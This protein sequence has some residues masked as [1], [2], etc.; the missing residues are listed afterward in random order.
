MAQAIL[1]DVL[2]HL[3]RL[4]E[5]RGARDLTD[6]EL[7]DRFRTR[8]EEAA[9]AV[10]VE[11]H[12]RMVLGVCRRVLGDAHA[13]EDA[14][15]AT[16]L[17]L[18]RRTASVRKRDSVVAWL[19]G[20][21][22]RIALRAKAQAAARR[23]RERQANP[24]PRADRL[25]E[26]TWQELRSALDE[27]V[28]AL[29]EKYR[30]PVVLCYLEGKSYEQA[31][32]ELGCPKSSLASRLA[33]ARAL[34]R[35]QLGR[36]GFGLPAGALAGTFAEAADAAP[37][38]ALLTLN[39]VKAA[40][41]IAAGKA[42]PGGCLSARALA[43][44][45]EA[46]K[47]IPG[48]K[49]KLALALLALALAVGGA[50]AG[51]LLTAS[52]APAAEVAVL[53]GPAP[54]GAEEPAQPAAGKGRLQGRITDANTGRP[55]AGA[56]IRVLIQGVPDKAA[57]A[58]ARSDGDGQY[59]L[60][61]PLGHCN[62]W[63]VYAPP[64]Y[65]TQDPKAFGT[66]LT[67]A[68]APHV[69]R[70]FVLQPGS[71]WRVELHGVP[72]PLERPP[73]FSAQRDPDRQFFAKG[74]GI[75]VIG[76]V[77]GKGVLTIPTAA[78]HYRFAGGLMTSPSRYEFPAADL[79]IDEG[80]DPRRIQGVPEPLKER[81]AVRLRDAAGR[82]AV[83]E[84]AEVRIEAGQAVL[85]F[86]AQPIPVAAALVFRGRAV[87]E[88]GKPLEGA[89]VTA[90]FASRN[91]GAMSQLKARTDARG[92]FVMRD[93]LLPQGFFEPDRR[94][95]MVVVKPGFHGAQ[96][97]ELGLPEVKTAG[98]GDFGT[99][100]LKPGRTL[101]GKVVDE[102]GRPL[103]GALVT[104]M[105]NY[106]LYSNLRCRTDTDGRFDMPD[107]AYGTQKL[108]AQY[109][110]RAGHADFPFDADSGDCVVTAR[111]VPQSGVRMSAAA[112]PRPARPVP[113]PPDDGPWDLAPPVK[114][115]RY[116]NEPR[117]AL[118]VF[119]PKRE[120]RVWMVLDGTTLYV[121]RN[122][123]GDLTEPGEQL[124]PNNPA[125]GSN[126]FGGSGSHTHFDV[127]EFTVQAG[128]AGPTK[129]RLEHWVRAENFTPKTD[130]D[131]Q[132]H[133]K[134]QKLGY[135]N[136]TLWRKTGLGQGQ[137]PVLFMPKPADAQVCALDGPLTFVVKLPEYQV[138]RRGEAGG[139]VAFHIV[140]P[141]RPPRTVGGQFHNPLAT[142]EVPEG[143]HLEVEIEYPAKVANDPPPRRK[144]LLKQRC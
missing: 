113:P 41:V 63:G 87:D 44:T 143:A 78:G 38:A 94:T 22:R 79:D 45:E 12:G 115:P 144:Y 35:R 6:G 124:E 117:Y 14:F 47:E 138:L 130:F 71:P 93:V 114:E 110:E 48:M 140:V 2:R 55:V 80:F 135:E 20:V 112:S 132:L 88:D 51:R 53:P 127:Y 75:S 61:V 105:T 56:T 67:T 54:G 25:E 39:T 3:R 136:S 28:G 64:G 16:F 58:E 123:N 33:R 106:F 1:G 11:R 65:Y 92:E 15:Q 82:S 42:A 50:A 95:Y 84:G 27:E 104:N 125:D 62:V 121:D 9:F 26:L 66:I 96:S 77:S 108:E 57:L 5:P 126:R 109:G 13:A 116:R 119:G 133:A 111:L 46:M 102:N 31:A 103:H 142:S 8:R 134:R 122:G 141:G 83:V 73:L 70:D 69:V 23:S 100:V 36:R 24:M 4:A 91:G 118:L 30:A 72:V 52:P 59:A 81:K 40:T 43:L 21:A 74:E 17:V 60:D 90:A 7:L 76:E 18:V 98:G 131:K 68:A 139:D 85:R 32:R 137:T 107:L 128:A 19:Y 86:H 34:L 29:P 101:R 10:L 99:V 120:T 129:I 97:K 49:G 37:V 89:E